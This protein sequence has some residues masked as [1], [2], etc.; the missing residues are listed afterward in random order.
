MLFK[1]DAEKLQTNYF[2]VY[3]YLKEHGDCVFTA[4]EILV[5]TA[6]RSVA[7]GLPMPT[8]SI[9]TVKKYLDRLIWERQVDRY[10][11]SGRVYYGLR[12]MESD[13]R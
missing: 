3:N 9:S 4:E 8:T 2:T 13:I 11:V 10:Y 1:R 12:T 5:G 6:E 7:N